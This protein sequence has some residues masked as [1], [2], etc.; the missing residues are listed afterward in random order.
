MS[1]GVKQNLIFGGL[2]LALHHPKYWRKSLKEA[3]EFLHFISLLQHFCVS[4]SFCQYRQFLS[5][6]S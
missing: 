3:E 5:F 1:H 4:D 6:F 2:V